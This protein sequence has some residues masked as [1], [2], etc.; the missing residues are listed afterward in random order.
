MSCTSDLHKCMVVIEEQVFT[1]VKEQDVS[2][3]FSYVRK[4]ELEGIRTKM[5]CVWSGEN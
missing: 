2:S 4:E 1:G 3:F 5:Y